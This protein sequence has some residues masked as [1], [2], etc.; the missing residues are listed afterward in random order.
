MEEFDYIIL[1]AGAAGSVLARRLSEDPAA[2]V[3][4]VE[5]GIPRSLLRN[6]VVQPRSQ[7]LT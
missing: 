3:L 6:L 2:R 1:G 4:V 7:E 5:A